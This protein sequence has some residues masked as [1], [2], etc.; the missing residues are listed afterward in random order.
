MRGARIVLTSMRFD[1]GTKVAAVILL[2]V[3]SLTAPWF[4]SAGLIVVV[5]GLEFLFPAFRPLSSVAHKLFLRFV[6]VAALFAVIVVVVNGI[7]MQGES[8]LSVGMISLSRPGVVFGLSV[9]AR[10][11]LLSISLLAFFVST[12]IRVVGEFFKSLG[13]PDTLVSLTLLSLYYV[14]QLPGR[15]A[16]IFMAQE[17]RGAPVR[18]NIFLRARSLVAV[19]S[20]LVLSS[21]VESIDRGLALE[22]RGFRARVQQSIARRPFSSPLAILFLVASALL[23]LQQ[24]AQWLSI[25]K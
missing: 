25:W 22:L 10:L 3:C 17:A 24:I 1:V 19:L 14:G 18:A 15:I 6:L 12:P 11:I 8:M 4:V 13:I 5:L 23:L 16:Q 7:L 2:A 20:P 9:S 21:L